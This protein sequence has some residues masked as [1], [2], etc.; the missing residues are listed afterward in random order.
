[1]IPIVPYPLPILL[2]HLVAIEM[3]LILR[4]M[5]IT[6][7]PDEVLVLNQQA[8]FISDVQPAIRNGTDTKTEAVPMHRVRNI[9]EQFTYPVFIPRQISGNRICK[10]PVQCDV[11]ATHEIHMSIEVSPLGG[12]IEAK[13]TH[14]ESRARAIAAR[15]RVHD[16]K[17]RRLWCPEAHPWNR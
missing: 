16:I 2:N 3:N 17:V 8:C 5:P 10:K 4:T 15:R 1:M 9:H 7:C 11:R 6:P 13:L 12:G 14:S